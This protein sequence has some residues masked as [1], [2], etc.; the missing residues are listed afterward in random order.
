[1]THRRGN[2]NANAN[3]LILLATALL[4]PWMVSSGTP[5]PAQYYSD[6]LVDHDAA[7]SAEQDDTTSNQKTY[8]TQRYYTW[9]NEF[10]GPGHPIFL[11]MGGEGNIEPSTGLFYPY[12]THHLAK[13]FGAFVLQPEHRFY[14]ESQPAIITLEH[15]PRPKLFTPKQA[16]QDAMRLLQ[17]YQVHELGCSA[18]KTAPDYCPVITVGGSYPGW[19]SA[20]ARLLFPNIVDMAYAASAPMLFYSQQVEPN[21]YYN[22]ISKVAEKSLPGCFQN[23]KRTLYVVDIILQAL[24]LNDLDN[25][26]QAFG[27]CPDSRPGYIQDLH[28]TLAHEL[29]MIIGY[30]FANDNMA[31]YPPDNTT[32]LHASCQVFANTHLDP[33]QKVEQFIKMHYSSKQTNKCVDMQQTQVPTGPNATI[34]GGDWSG[35]G[36]GSSGESWDFQTCT[37]LV[38][39]IGFSST[40]SMFPAR[41][42]TMEWMTEH[43]QSRFHVTPEPL[44]LVNEWHFDDLANAANASH[45]LFTNGLN[46]GWSVGGIMSNLSETLLALNF[47]N[48]AHHSDLSGTGPSDRDTLDIQQGFLHIRDLFSDWLHDLPGGFYA[49][50]RYNDDDGTTARKP[51]LKA[52][53]LRLASA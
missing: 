41:N 36:F 35:V 13:H 6:Q 33:V 34:S 18:N 52:S 31:N 27:F 46:D 49:K 50:Q 26:V 29:F 28:P 4:L 15:D 25:M 19:L 1:M 2:N 45:I 22:H 24:P 10:K 39:R 8:W 51:A 5:A 37:L 12:I 14:G 42:W 40:E 48:G 44:K 43:C 21:A 32:K 53:N 3:A 16:L 7:D 30:T 11:I 47:E 9:D 38:E 23:V 20:M 17:Q